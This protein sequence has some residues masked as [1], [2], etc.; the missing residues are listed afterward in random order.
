M[1]EYVD[2]PS[3]YGVMAFLLSK[4][5][6]HCQN[7]KQIPRKKKWTSDLDSPLKA[8]PTFSVKNIS[9]SHTNINLGEASFSQILIYMENTD[10][11][12]GR[13]LLPEVLERWNLYVRLTLS[14]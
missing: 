12:Y 8:I 11:F 1:V 7:F 13:L 14:V 9:L 4:S 2:Y 5:V 10:V 6:C 3:V